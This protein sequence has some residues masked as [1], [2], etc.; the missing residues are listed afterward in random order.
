M[1]THINGRRAICVTSDRW[2]DDTVP[3]DPLDRKDCPYK[4]YGRGASP[5]FAKLKHGLWLQQWANRGLVGQGEQISYKNRLTMSMLRARFSCGDFTLYIIWSDFADQFR[6]GLVGMPATFG[7][8]VHFGG[9]VLS[10][11]EMYTVCARLNL[12][13][14]FRAYFGSNICI[15]HLGHLICE[16]RQFC[17]GGM[18]DR[19][20]TA[21]LKQ[22]G[23]IL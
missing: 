9:R 2:S 12:N 8:G 7:D 10:T 15:H 11:E 23:N 1:K 22:L 20:V 13:S 14:R 17:L 18:T 19:R 16:T 5:E 4:L 6:P 3:P 21:L